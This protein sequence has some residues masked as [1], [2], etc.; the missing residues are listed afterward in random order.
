VLKKGYVE[1]GLAVMSIAA[2]KSFLAVRR[3]NG[4]GERWPGFLAEEADEPFDILRS[5]RQLELIANELQSPQ[6]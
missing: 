4:Y 1:S 6:A 3:L 2:R 5:R